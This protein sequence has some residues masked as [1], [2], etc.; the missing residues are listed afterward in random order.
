[1]WELV[2]EDV[3]IVCIVQFSMYTVYMH[4]YIYINIQYRYEAS[5]Q[6]ILLF[7]V[8]LT[9]CFPFYAFLF[10]L[11]ACSEAAHL[12]GVDNIGEAHR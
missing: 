6:N 3:C 9:E 5:I 8:L 11:D 4:I 12:R 7:T 1:M 10:L 2:F